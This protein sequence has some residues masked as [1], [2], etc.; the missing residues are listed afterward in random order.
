MDRLSKKYPTI[1]FHENP[2]SGSRRHTDGRTDITKLIIALRNFANTPKDGQ[3]LQSFC[4]RFSKVIH[5][6]LE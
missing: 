3:N 1:K 4:A 2:S 5:Q 6:I